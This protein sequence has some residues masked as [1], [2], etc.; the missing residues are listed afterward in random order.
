MLTHY[1]AKLAQQVSEF[2]NSSQELVGTFNRP[3]CGTVYT[4]QT[5]FREN[6]VI[7]KAIY[8]QKPLR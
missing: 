2:I 5:V 7:D 3:R 6:M 1:M 4:K 8:Y